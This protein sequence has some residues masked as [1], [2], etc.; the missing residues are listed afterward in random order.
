ML[1]SFSKGYTLET[2]ESP[3]LFV[4]YHQTTFTQQHSAVHAGELLHKNAS[5]TCL[6]CIL[7]CE[8]IHIVAHQ[9][10]TQGELMHKYMRDDIYFDAEWKKL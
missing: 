5:L 4:H 10:H 2:R 3:P 9:T 7:M 8:C 6:R 1:C